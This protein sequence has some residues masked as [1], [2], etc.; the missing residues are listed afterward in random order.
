[1]IL[2]V[3]ALSLLMGLSL[4][5]LGGGG[6]ILAVPMLVYVVG[7]GAKQAIATSLLVVGATSVS[8]A[9]QHARAGHVRWRTGLVFGVVAMIGAYLGGL[10]AGFIP[11][12]VLLG[13]FAMMMVLA[14]VA[15]L[16][17]RGSRASRAAERSF[18]FWKI[19]LDGLVVGAAT[20]LVGAGGGFLVVPALLLFGGLGMRAAIGTSTLVIAMKSFA[21]FAGHAAHVTVDL[22]LA[23]L[24]ISAAVL[25]SIVGAR[26]AHRTDPARLRRGFAVFVLLM[27]GVILYQEAP[28]ALLHTVFVQAWPVWAA[29]AA[30]SLSMLLTLIMIGR[31]SFRFQ[32]EPANLS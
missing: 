4:G 20:G 16:R 26:L 12:G 2:L 27:A 31:A 9:V 6:S 8:C 13:L 19:S 11:G 14:A 1:M 17:R 22:Q 21:G 28:A 29:A 32:T 10:V 24:V 15:M 30:I 25:G 5:L 7:L 18:S 3:A 23:A